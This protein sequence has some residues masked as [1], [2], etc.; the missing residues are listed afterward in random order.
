MLPGA[1]LWTQEGVE[2]EKELEQAQEGQEEEEKQCLDFPRGSALLAC[3]FISPLARVSMGLP[4]GLC[5]APSERL[6]GYL[7]PLGWGVLGPSWR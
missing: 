3:A 6:L 1:R 2:G 5:A 7:T 4:G